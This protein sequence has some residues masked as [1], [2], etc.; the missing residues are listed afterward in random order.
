MEQTMQGPAWLGHGK[1]I[2]GSMTKER[3]VD[4]P[5]DTAT[6][7]S[8]GQVGFVYSDRGVTPTVTTSVCLFGTAQSEGV[9]YS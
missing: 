5:R 4:R 6:Q 9:S 7:K 8:C 1:L 3:R 2:R